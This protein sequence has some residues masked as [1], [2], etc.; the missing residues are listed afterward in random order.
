M[1]KSVWGF[2][3]LHYG[4]DPIMDANKTL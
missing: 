3:L 2:F 1:K 4:S